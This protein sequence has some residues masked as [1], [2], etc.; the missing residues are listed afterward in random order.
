[1]T[2]QSRL[3]TGGTVHCRMIY[4]GFPCFFCL[5]LE[6]GHA[7]AFWLLLCELRTDAYHEVQISQQQ[8]N[9]A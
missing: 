2:I 9:V 8:P 6:D 4:D 3:K 1:M 7:P 5:G